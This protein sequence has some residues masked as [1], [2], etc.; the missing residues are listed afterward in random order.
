MLKAPPHKRGDT[1]YKTN[2][3]SD[4]NGPVNIAGWTITSQLRDPADVKIA[5]CVVA[6]T[7]AAAGAYSLTVANTTAWPLGALF[8]DIQYIDG[9]GVIFS[10]ETIQVVILMDITR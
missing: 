4:D 6:I 5:D 7:D 9:S 2:V 1:F 10:T 3:V 8:W